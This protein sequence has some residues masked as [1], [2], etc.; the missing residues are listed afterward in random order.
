MGRRLWTCVLALGLACNSDSVAPDG[1]RDGR[2]DRS[3]DSAGQ[4][5][6]PP[7]DALVDGQPKLPDGK[8]KPDV[9]SPPSKACAALP[10]PTG[11]TV[12]VKPAQ[13][14]QLASI[15]AAA[16]SGTTILLEDGTY[17]MT[18]NES[19]RRLTFAVPSVTL[20]SLSGD[21]TKV[22][23]D[24]EYLTNEMVFI[25][26]T[27]V[28]IADVTLK[29]A[30]DHLVHVTGSA[31]GVK[32]I[33]LYN[34]QL[35]DSGE[36]FVKINGDGAGHFV[37]DGRLECSLLEMTAAGRPHIETNPGGCYTG[38][39]DA[40]GA[41]GWQ[42]RYN[43][44]KDIYCTNGSL[45]EHAVHFWSASR[46]TLVERNV[47]IN[48]ARGV[49]FGL[50]QTGATR[51]YTDNPYPG[52][53]YLGHIDGIIRNN[54]IHV[55][56]AAQPYY[57]TGIEISQARLVRVYHNTLVSKALFSGIDYRWE[58]TQV[59]VRNNLTTKITVRDSAKGTEDHNLQS[60]PA[61]LFVNAA[62]IDYHLLATASAAINKGVVVSEAGLDLDGNPHTVGVPDLGAYERQP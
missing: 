36:Q 14:A 44:F 53:A 34:L 2:G 22:I 10:A 13:A 37:D 45:A 59:E 32:T 41:Q 16:A 23:I 38:G 28:T 56:P 25:S 48:C 46:D 11:K 4:E 33:R 40:H 3:G 24:G 26:A 47:I 43:T 31:A 8:L 39:I 60:A 17:T 9:A 21:R 12:Q 15:V 54:V 49:G 6:R 52:V 35:V 57:D 27:G 50:G 19:Q 51:A 62:A 30:V 61:S 29:R 42:V 58:N 7:S 20:R 1:G 5:A 18:G 55:D